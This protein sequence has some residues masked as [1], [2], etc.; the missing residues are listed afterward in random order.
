MESLDKEFIEGYKEIGRGQG[1]DEGFLT[2]FAR[3]YIEPGDLAMEDLAKETG[4]S[5]ASISNKVNMFGHIIPIKKSRK[6]GSKKVYLYMDK[7]IIGMVKQ[8]MVLK[9]IHGINIIKDKLPGIL[10]EYKGK[11][12]SEKDKKKLKILENY[13]SQS[14][15]FEVILNKMSKELDKIK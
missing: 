7:D 6:P 2:I 15:K 4:Y 8:A 14:L 10:K 11:V 12:K 9:Q 5:L 1:V 13:Y 3:L